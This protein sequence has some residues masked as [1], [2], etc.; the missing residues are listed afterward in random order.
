MEQ[1]AASPTAAHRLQP[2]TGART[3]AHRAD[4]VAVAADGT[5]AAGAGGLPADS[6]GA[7]PTGTTGRRRGW[8]SRPPEGAVTVAELVLVAAAAVVGVLSTVALAAGHLGIFGPGVVFGVSALLVVGLAVLARL[9]SAAFPRIALDPAGLLPAAA[10]GVLALVMFLPGFHYAAGDK[11]PGVYVMHAMAIARGHSIWIHDPLL[12]AGNLPVQL[13]APGARFPGIWISDAATGTIFPQFYHLWP[14]LLATSYD[15]G[16]YGALVA[17]TPLLGV[18]GVML[19]VAVARR[20]AGPVAAWAAAVLMSTNM[21]QVWQAKYP[22]AEIL[23]QVLFVGALLGVLLAV[24]TRWRWPALVAGLLVTIGYLGR[25]DGILLVLFAVGLL[26]L[27]WVLRRWDARAGWFA[28]GLA[29]PLPY[30]FWQAYGPAGAYTAANDVPGLATMVGLIAVCVVGALVLRPLLRGPVGR[31]D[32]L[33]D[34]PRARLWFGV[35]VTAVSVGLFALGRLR[36]RLFGADYFYYGSR[37]TRSYD[38]MNLERLSWF[39]TWPGMLL[40]LAGIG[41]VALAR[42]WSPSAWLVMVPTAGLLALY[43]W[44]LRNSPYYMWVGRRFVPSVL[45][46]MFVLIGL[47]LAA[48]WMWKFRGRWRIGVPLAV[49][50]VAFIGGVQLSQS[51]PLRSHDEWGGSYGVNQSLAALSGDQKG[52]YLWA[53]A[54]AC[55]AQSVQLFGPTIWLIEDEDSALLPAGPA[56]GPYV[57]RYAQTFPG[58]PLFLVYET[59]TV[60]PQLPGLKRTPVARFAGTMPHWVESSVSRPDKA[61]QIPYD[62]TVYRV[63]P[64]R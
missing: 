32:G 54:T 39:F 38:E 63:T 58:R 50:L 42:R 20:I 24:Q 52:I 22:T 37:Y 56:V 2:D 14:A 27:L 6:D 5:I 29:V 43:I 31:L 17:T 7:E 60:V 11:D 16:G 25:P 35:L 3:G 41:V 55:C 33:L 47:A 49:A 48:L 21:M 13:A 30:A 23:S 64:A 46:G 9:R 59:R 61:L 1:P 19:T 44:H 26:A 45:P 57:T 28:V 51:L 36:G 4:G 62:F 34:R 40:V 18:L 8:W 15:V 53:P 10:G 12:A